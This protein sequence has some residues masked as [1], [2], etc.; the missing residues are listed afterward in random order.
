MIRLFN[1]NFNTLDIIKSKD[2]SLV[3]SSLSEFYQPVYS[4][5]FSIK[6]V[7]E[8]I[9]RYTL[10]NRQYP[11]ET[12]KYLLSNNTMEGNVAIE[13]GKNAK[14]ICINVLP[15]LIAEVVASRQRPD[16]AFSD[17][18]LGRFFTSNLFFENQYNALNTH[19]GKTLLNL[20]KAIQLNKISSEDLTIEFF[21][22]ISEQIIADQIPIFRQLQAIPSLK[23]ATKKDLYRKLLRGKDFADAYFT[24][25]LTISDIA[26]EACM[27]EYHFYR[28]FKSVFGKS[29]NQYLIQKR[30]DFSQSML[31]SGA[32]VSLTSAESGFVDIH[33]FSKTFKKHFGVSPTLYIRDKMIL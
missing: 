17:A 9:E 32:S 21:Y 30:L 5:G 11:I 7:V 33:T 10:N 12:G 25:P 29:P 15:E 14:G 8:G 6:Y 23:S 4:N 13:R 27:S 22:E 20:T 24:N 18:D 26:Q 1:E 2:N 19:L 31:Q 28:L 3:F 16:T